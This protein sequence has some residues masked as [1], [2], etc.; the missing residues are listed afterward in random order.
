MKVLFERGVRLLERPL[1]L[2]P[3]RLLVLAALLLAPAYFAPLWKVTIH[4]PAQPEGLRLEI[5]SYKLAGGTGG[6]DIQGIND[7]NHSIGMRDVTTEDFTEFK[8]I[9]FA[10]G[11][12]ALLFLRTAALG[13]LLTAVD[14]LV[15][16]LYFGLFS[17]WSFAYKLYTYGHSLASAASVKVAPFM[18]PLFGHKVIANF[19]V[20]LIRGRLLRSGGGS[21]RSGGRRVLRLARG[22]TCGSH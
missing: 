21:C 11:A 2:G 19:E 6:Q 18:P 13:K 3:R 15:L 14:T 20:E 8:W 4:A 16:Y 10:V 1:D 17:L 22:T 7:L 12:L 5:Y 9:P